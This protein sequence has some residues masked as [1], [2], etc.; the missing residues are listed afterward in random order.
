LTS[1]LPDATHQPEAVHR[2]THDNILG[3]LK[4]FHDGNKVK[5]SDILIVYLAGHGVTG[6]G[7]D[8]SFY[9]LTSDAQ[10]ADSIDPEVRRQWSV[11]DLE[12]ITEIMAIPAQRQV[13]ILDTCHSG[14][15]I[16]NL[17]KPREPDTSEVIALERIRDHTGFHV[18]A[19]SAADRASYEASHYNQGVLTYSLLRGMR[20]EA[21]KD[22]RFVDVNTLF[23]F[24]VNNVPRLA[25]DVQGIQK[26]ETYSDKGSTFPFGEIT[27][28][29][30]PLIP[31][32]KTRPLVLRAYF[33]DAGEQDPLDLSDKLNDRFH[34]ITYGQRDPALEF[35]DANQLTGAYRVA[36]SYQIE[37]EKVTGTVRMALQ[38]PE[39][40]KIE[41][42]AVS[43]DK[44]KIAELV[45][46]IAAGVQKRLPPPTATP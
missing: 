21:L 31:L 14:K 25:G 7:A 2:P 46:E 6:G 5:P 8:N 22:G 1:P 29:D 23:D 34:E 35:V 28:A 26:P 3:A 9:Y 36:G 15:L 44:T 13:M 38:L 10:A 20:G 45:T 18:L 17:S 27:A 37:G 43:G 30:Q 16:E 19:G 4:A 41:P 24:A 11:S 33:H 42:F 39:A 40:G 32:A 12:M